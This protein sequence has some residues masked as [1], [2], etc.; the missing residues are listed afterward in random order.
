MLANDAIDDI[1]AR[2]LSVG[3]DFP[4]LNI[5]GDELRG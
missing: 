2:L 3:G 5:D 4:G 1:P